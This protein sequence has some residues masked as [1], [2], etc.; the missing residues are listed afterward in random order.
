MSFAMFRGKDLFKEI[1][2]YYA[3]VVHQPVHMQ[4]F[5]MCLF[6]VNLNGVGKPPMGWVHTLSEGIT[7]S[8]T[9]PLTNMFHMT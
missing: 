8:H 3:V 9:Q 5:K 1:F 4:S 6:F 7:H 2:W